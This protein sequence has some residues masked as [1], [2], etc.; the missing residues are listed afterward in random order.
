MM[1]AQASGSLA[2]FIEQ[3]PTRLTR[4]DDLNPVDADAGIPSS[5][6]RSTRT[7]GAVSVTLMSWPV[8]VSSAGGLVG[9]LVPRT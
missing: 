5:K 1:R 8:E 7:L 6:N 4:F 9:S 3:H 2:Y